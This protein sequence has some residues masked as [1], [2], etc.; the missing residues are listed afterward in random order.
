MNRLLA[1]PRRVLAVGTLAAVAVVVATGYGYAAVTADN[2]TYTGCLQSGALTNIAIGETP[3]KACPKNSTQISWN[4]TGPQGAQGLQGI[5]GIPGE[6]GEHGDK[7]DPGVQGL[8]GEQGPPGPQ[9]IPGPSGAATLASLA[10]SECVRTNGVKGNVVVNVAGTGE[11]G[12]SNA[13][14]LT[15]EGTTNFC[16]EST[17]EV[18]PHMTVAC[19]EATDTLSFTCDDDWH[20]INDSTADGCELFA[21]LPLTEEVARAAANS[22]L[23][24]TQDVTVAAN[25]AATPTIGCPGGV[26]VDSQVRVSG[27]DI[28]LTKVAAASR[29]DVTADVSLTTLTSIPLGL[30]GADCQLT[31]DTAAGTN[32]NAQVHLP[33]H[34]LPPESPDHI[35][36]GAVQ[37]TGLEAAD[38]QISG[39]LFCQVA[40]IGI[41]FFLG[42]VQDAV[43]DAVNARQVEFCGAPGPE[44]FMTCP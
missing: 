35:T 33:L 5:P 7:G 21:L 4:Q 41:G 26:P 37:F 18:G 15:C 27:S 10:G 17:P 43:A 30:P 8:R 40:D 6:K 32:A 14:T 9:G 34:F 29:F 16:A 13:I 38:F 22:L 25:C 24:G 12:L 36:T 19:D 42:I 31:I 3:L 20:D 44:L 1:T 2:Q 28:G 39:G 11:P 23:L